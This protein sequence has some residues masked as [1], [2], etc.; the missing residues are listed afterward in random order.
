MATKHAH[1]NAG[2]KSQVTVRFTPAY[3]S[4]RVDNSQIAHRFSH[5]HEQSKDKRMVHTPR[6]ESETMARK[7]DK[8]ER[9]AQTLE[10]KAERAIKQAQ[11]ESQVT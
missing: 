6:D 7:W 3:A 5:Y 10:R 4:S 11:V 2:S 8:V 9:K 1:Y